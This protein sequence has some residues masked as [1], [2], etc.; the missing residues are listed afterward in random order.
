[1]DHDRVVVLLD[2]DEVI[3]AFIVSPGEGVDMDAHLR[4]CQEYAKTSALRLV[5]MRAPVIRTVH[6]MGLVDSAIHSYALHR[7]VACA[8]RDVA[9]L[10]QLGRNELCILAIGLR[11]LQ[12]RPDGTPPFEALDEHAMAE[13]VAEKLAERDRLHVEHA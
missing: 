4:E 9:A 1:M 8:P 2:G 6:E 12:G 10:K 5:E 3:A 11:D 7:Y 13:R